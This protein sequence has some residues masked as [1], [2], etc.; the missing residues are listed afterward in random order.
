MT[1]QNWPDGA[2]IL[3]DG[4]WGT[5]FHKR[6]LTG[7]ECS[8]GW[9][10]LHPERVFA[11]AASYVEAGSDII[12]TNTFRANRVALAGYGLAEELEPINREG[13]RISREAAATVR[14][15]HRRVQVFASFGTTGKILAAG[16][17]SRED[18][19][20]AFR[21]QTAILAAAG[22][23]ALIMETVSDI[24]EASAG[25]AAARE[26]GLPVWISFVFD[27][28][29]NKDRTMTG[30]TPEQAARRMTDEGAA[31]VGANC[32]VG[33]AEYVPVCRRLRETTA[34]PLWIKPNAGL[35]TIENGQ[36]VYA[37]TPEQFAS[38]IP[39]LV[40]AGAGVVGGCCGS[41][42]DFIRAVARAK[43]NLCV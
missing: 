2:P 33:I 43:A 19:L 1:S 27:T 32:G 37:T 28:G 24:E 6:G 40:A 8:D 22:A 30:V 29:R 25:L 13:V 3:S 35:P 41:N 39:Q 20:A 15:P 17:I 23:D 11:V 31:G 16:E 14:P 4:A 5:E 36:A 38:Y 10:L 21:E 42:P 9:N 18:A 7:G 26:T 12:L 34:L